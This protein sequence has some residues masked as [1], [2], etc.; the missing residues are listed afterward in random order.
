MAPL[1]SAM[2]SF[3]GFDTS[4]FP[5][6]PF[7]SSKLVLPLF[8]A[9]VVLIA[10]LSVS[11]SVGRIEVSGTSSHSPQPTP[12]S[13]LERRSNARQQS[14][15]GESSACPPDLPGSGLSK[16]ALATSKGG[17]GESGTSAL[18]LSSYEGCLPNDRPTDRRLGPHRQ[19][20]TGST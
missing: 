8:S 2:R 18:A 5:S 16:Q 17:T 9:A 3:D 20:E 7:S 4:F 13:F 14:G 1:K 6:N 11:I 15:P 19:N 12:S 10:S